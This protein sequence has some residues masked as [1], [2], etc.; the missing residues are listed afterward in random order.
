MKKITY[1]ILALILTGFFISC[2]STKVVPEDATAAQ[3]IQMGQNAFSSN[4]YEEAENY[5]ETAIE[6]FGSDPK[7]YVEAKYEIGHIYVKTKDYEKA[8]KCFNEIIDL[9]NLDNRGQLPGTYKK[10]A[11]LGL[12][13]I[14]ENKR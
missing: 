14:P 10:L 2:K 3:I 8:S 7:V 4:K 6:R 13:K 12:S 5:Y 9:Y 1:I 11:Q